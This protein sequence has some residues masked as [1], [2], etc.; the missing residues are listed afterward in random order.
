[1]ELVAV[2]S[3]CIGGIVSIIAQLQNSRCTKVKCC[4]VTCD[5]EISQIEKVD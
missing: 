5:R 2:V 4:G 3:V 1:M